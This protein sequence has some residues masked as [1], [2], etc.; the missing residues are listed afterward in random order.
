MALRDAWRT[1]AGQAVRL[2]VLAAALLLM[3]AAAYHVAALTAYEASA[4]PGPLAA[5]LEHARVA[6]WLE[7]WQQRFA[8]RVVAIEGLELLDA[9]RIDDAYR[10]LE[11]Y[12]RVV[13]GDGVYRAAYQEAVRLKTPL[14]ARKAHVQHAREQAGGYLREQDVIH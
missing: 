11:P 8:W 13:R 2:A 6:A 12:S 9:G 10:L 1:A 4:G 3:A 14:D 5:R 7:P